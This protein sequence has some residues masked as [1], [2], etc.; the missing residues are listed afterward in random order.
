MS[1]AV[2]RP[3]VV[4]AAVGL[5]LAMAVAGLVYAALA[6]VTVRGTIDRYRADARVSTEDVDATVGGIVANTVVLA[7]VG[8]GAAVLLVILALG[9]LRGMAGFRIATWVMCGLG[10][11]CGAGAVLW[12]LVQRAGRWDAAALD[13]LAGSYPSWWL[14]LSGVLSAGQALG[15]LVVALLLAL[16]AAHPFFRRS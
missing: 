5:M 12:S 1:V 9:V 14:W 3:A 7:V 16:P 4:T 6:V 15:Y 13:A 8:A 10:L 2:R 11:L